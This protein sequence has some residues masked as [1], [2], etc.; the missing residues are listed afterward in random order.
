MMVE[1]CNTPRN[2]M[3]PEKKKNDPPIFL[4]QPKN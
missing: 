1:V 3:V 2:E 4:N